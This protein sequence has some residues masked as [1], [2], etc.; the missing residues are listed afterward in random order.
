M[1]N[2]FAEKDIIM[3]L[4]YW[5]L[6]VHIIF[7]ECKVGYTSRN[8]KPC[9]QCEAGMYGKRCIY[10]CKCEGSQRCHHVRGCISELG[11]TRIPSSVY[12]ITEEDQIN[13][14]KAI[15]KQQLLLYIVSA[16]CFVLLIGVFFLGW[17]YKK[18]SQSRRVPLSTTHHDTNDEKDLD[19]N[20]VNQNTVSRFESAYDEI[21]ESCIVNSL[22]TLTITK[23]SKN[24]NILDDSVLTHRNITEQ[25]TVSSEYLTP[26]SGNDKHEDHCDIQDTSIIIAVETPE[27]CGRLHSAVF[28]YLIP[29]NV[30]QDSYVSS[31]V[32]DSNSQGD[33]YLHPYTSVIS[34]LQRDTITADIQTENQISSES[35]E[36][37]NDHKYSNLYEQLSHNWKDNCPTYTH[38]LSSQHSITHGT[39]KKVHIQNKKVSN[40]FQKDEFKIAPSFNEMRTTSQ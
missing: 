1:N 30:Y 32:N 24:T 16:V 5:S 6:I 7:S 17:K 10:T 11:V 20:L 2:L 40:T 38:P 39:A 33:E 28:D 26:I 9:H 12:T 13:R 3:F 8:G 31:H 36:E 22:T 37:A 14:D 23:P 4:T 27:C 29:V 19:I 18:K 34:S 15:T 35:D 21:D 25:N